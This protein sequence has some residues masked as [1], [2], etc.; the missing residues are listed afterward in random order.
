MP[1]PSAPAAAFAGFFS[2]PRK[3]A[4]VAD[5]KNAIHTVPIAM[6]I[7]LGSSPIKVGR[8]GIP[9]VAMA[10]RFKWKIPAKRPPETPPRTT[11]GMICLY[12]TIIP[13]TAGSVTPQSAVKPVENPSSF[14]FLSLLRRAKPRVAPHRPGSLPEIQVRILSRT[15]SLQ[16]GWS[17][18]AGK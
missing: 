1:C 12:F 16:A 10:Y 5:T 4:A 13:Y 14:T 18:E 11:A 7:L 8:A 3:K 6:K 9:G 15:P 17:A 2:A